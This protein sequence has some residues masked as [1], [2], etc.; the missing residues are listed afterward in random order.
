M[1][2]VMAENRNLRANIS[3]QEKMIEAQARE[4]EAAKEVLRRYVMVEKDWDG[5]QKL[6]VEFG[7]P[8]HPE[9]SIS[10]DEWLERI[11]RAPARAVLAQKE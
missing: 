8:E 5:Y 7:E 9:C 10:M 4:I 2:Q 1:T 3:V 6:Y 11:L